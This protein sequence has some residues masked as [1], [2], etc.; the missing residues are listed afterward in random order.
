MTPEEIEAVIAY[1]KSQHPEIC[2]GKVPVQF[3]PDQV[4]KALKE[5]ARRKS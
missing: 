2:R 4:R 5:F 1:L 3:S